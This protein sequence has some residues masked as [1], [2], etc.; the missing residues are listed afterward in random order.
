MRQNLRHPD[1]SAMQYPIANDGSMVSAMHSSTIIPNH[2]VAKMPFMAIE[3][4]SPNG[5][6]IE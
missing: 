6:A 4:V 1:Q 5:M 3:L 2:N